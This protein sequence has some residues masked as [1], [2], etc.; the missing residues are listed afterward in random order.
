[1]FSW[2]IGAVDQNFL[3]DEQLDLQTLQLFNG[4]IYLNEYILL[5]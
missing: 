5:S 4:I 1:M 3:Y 2:S